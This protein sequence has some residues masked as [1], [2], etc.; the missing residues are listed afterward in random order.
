MSCPQPH[1]SA[2][3]VFLEMAAVE[4]AQDAVWTTEAP[5]VLL[6]HCAPREARAP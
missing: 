1:S 3:A 2:L 5:A 6:A 4:G